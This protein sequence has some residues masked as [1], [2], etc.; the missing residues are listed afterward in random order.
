[1]DDAEVDK[2]TRLRVDRGS[3][4]HA[5]AE[6]EVVA[7]AGSS[8]ATYEDREALEGVLGGVAGKRDEET[9]EWLLREHVGE[10]LADIAVENDLPPA[11]V[12]QRV[13][14]LRRALRSRWAL[15]VGV[16]TLTTVVTVGAVLTHSSPGN[17]PS[18]SIVQEPA[19]R[20]ENRPLAGAR[21]GPLADALTGALTGEWVVQSV[22]PGRALSL[23][24]QRIL[25]TDSRSA[26][27]RIGS[28]AIGLDLRN[29]HR[30]WAIAAAAPSAPDELRLDL[31]AEGDSAREEATVRVTRDAQGPRL[32]VQF[33][34][35]TVILRRPVL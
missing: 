28:D 12:R 26:V 35:A 8:P 10:R 31:T 25:D 20:S 3:A 24:E 21:T 22:T 29:G 7:G 1:V 27:V 2:P 16:A 6:V 19:A 13:S 9:M 34:G 32:D 4:R 33:R 23:A 14:R 18:A 30:S 15:L 17:L 11:V 5:D